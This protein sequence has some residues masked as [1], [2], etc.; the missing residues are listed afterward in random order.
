L[1]LPL[2]KYP[3]YVPL[4]PAA[5]HGRYR[6][7][8]A[9]LRLFT[10][11]AAGFGYDDVTCH[12]K[13]LFDIIDRVEKR[14]VYFRVFHGITMS[15]QNETALYCFWIAKRA[16]FVNRKDPDHRINAYFAAFLF[17]RMLRV[18]GIKTRRPVSV[19]GKYVENLVYALLYRDLSKE[20]I[21]AMADALMTGARSAEAEG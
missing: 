4:T 15:E 11:H 2:G 20:A 8:D 1:S 12:R 9:L 5:A 7:L 19:D 17:L 13:V 10:R 14:R 16:P 21:M 3:R 18:V 6:K